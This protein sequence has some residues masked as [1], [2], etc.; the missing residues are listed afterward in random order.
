[1]KTTIGGLPPTDTVDGDLFY[2][3][4]HNL[5]VRLWWGI[6]HDLS[7]AAKVL[8]DEPIGD[9]ID[10]VAQ[11]GRAKL[12]D[13][14]MAGY[15]V[16]VFNAKDL[17]VDVYASNTHFQGVALRDYFTPPPQDLDLPEEWAL[18]ILPDSIL[19]QFLVGGATMGSAELIA[20]DLKVNRAAGFNYLLGYGLHAHQLTTEGSTFKK[21]QAVPWEQMEE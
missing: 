19:C 21:R 1:M 2:G 10:A 17:L 7:R 6:Y 16:G 3:P 18:E 14:L 11:Q 20:Q 8:P 4:D 13:Y 12:Y 5:R 15:E 9:L